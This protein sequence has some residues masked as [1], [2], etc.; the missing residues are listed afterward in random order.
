[1]APAHPYPK[2]IYALIDVVK[3]VLEDESLPFDKKKV[4]IGGGSAGANLAL[5]TAQDSSLQGKFGGLVAYYPPCDFTTPV[6]TAISTRPKHAGKDPLADK[7]EMFNCAYFADDQDLRDPQLSPR[8]ANRPK[9]PP[10]IYIVGCDFDMLCHDAEK[11]AESFASVGDGPRTGTDDCWEQN[12]VKWER[13][14]GEEHG[15]LI[16]REL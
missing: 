1:L 16:P 2:P 8:W 11:M 10:K 7:A 15:E 4:V 13:C 6:K 5:A 12:G 9:L 14:L 3:A